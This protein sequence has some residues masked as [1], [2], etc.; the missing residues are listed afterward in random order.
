MSTINTYIGTTTV[1]LT[2]SLTARMPIPATVPAKW[3]TSGGFAVNVTTTGL[4]G[5]FGVQ[6]IGSIA[7]I[8]FPIA[9][10]T[11]IGAGSFQITMIIY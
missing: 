6:V 11:A 10:R 5:T 7:G 2:A 1:G 3:F 8:S 9:G 4:S